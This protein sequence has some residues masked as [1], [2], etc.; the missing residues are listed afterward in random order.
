MSESETL[1][2][3][4]NLGQSVWYDNIDR[5]LIQN[6]ELSEIIS[7]GVRGLTSNPSIFEKA[8]S[9]SDVYDSDIEIMSRQGKSTSEIFEALAVSDIRNAAEILS[10]VYSESNGADGFVSLEVNPH[11][12]NDT[13]GTV[14]EA[15]RLFKA[16]N[17]PNLMIKVPA[18]PSGMPAIKTLISEGINVNVTLIFSTTS[19]SE[20]R[21][22]YISGLESLVNS[23]GDCSNVSSV[24][25]FFVSRV[26]TVVD[27]ALEAVK[28]DQRDLTGK[29]AIAN[30]KI[31]YRDFRESFCSNRFDILNKANARVQ[32]PLWASTSTKNPEL[33]DVLYVESLIGQDTVTTMPDST[34]AAY[35]DHGNPLPTLTDGVTEASDHLGTIAS[36]GID[37]EQLTEKLIVDGVKQFADSYDQVIKNISDKCEVLLVN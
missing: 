24:A 13:N 26:D 4:N 19:Y 11:L 33:S 32:R 1:A 9:S 6:G 27:G 17:K 10:N 21:E 20:V 36:L 15:R 22:A 14:E 25:S 31:A 18:T 29:S 7:T 37:L 16:V 34:L 3:L 2:K 5:R 35:N 23:G 12:A 30:A 28:S 8:I